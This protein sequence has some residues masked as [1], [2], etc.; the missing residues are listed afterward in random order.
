MTDLL[1]T[2]KPAQLSHWL[3][4]E[5]DGDLALQPRDLRFL[6]ERIGGAPEF[7]M[8]HVRHDP[9]ERHSVLL[10]RRDQ[11]DVWLLCWLGLQETGLHDHDRSAGALYV[12]EGTLVEDVLRF[13]SS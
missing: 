5:L 6:A 9:H 1:T 8:S 4:Q 12:H 7:W 2:S 3:D 10:H 13:N 11:L